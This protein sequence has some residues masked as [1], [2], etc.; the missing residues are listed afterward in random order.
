MTQF[1]L[2][3]IG[4]GP[5]GYE[6]ALEAAAA[7]KHVALI[8]ERAAGG[9]CLHEGC[10]PTKCLAHSAEVLESVKTA[11]A[12]GIGC[13]EATFS[14]PTAVERKD[15]VVQR[16]TAGIDALLKSAGVERIAG[17]AIMTADHTVSVGDDSLTAPHIIIATGSEARRLPIPGADLP[18]VVTSTEMLNLQTVPERLC[19]IGGGVIG[20]EF[21]GI[22]ATLGSTVTVIEYCKEILPPFDKDMAKRLRMILKKKG[23][24]FRLES[25]VERIEANADSGTDIHFQTKG[26][27]ATVQADLVL[28]AVGRA[29]R[30]AGLGLEQTAIAHSP[31]GIVTDDNM[32]TTVAGVYAIGDVN[33]R[34]PL[35]HAATF[36]GRRA[37]HHIL[38]HTDGIDFTLVPSVVYTQ[39]NLAQVGLREEDFADGKPT[40]VKAF[41]RANGRALTM[42]AEEGMVKLLFDADDHLRGAHILGEGA[43]EMIHEAAVLIAEGATRSRLHDIIHAHPTLS[44]MYLA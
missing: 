16:L 23:I 13:G 17:H 6:T 44:E 27:A 9:T 7:G 35:A 21:A 8:E 4:A 43:A 33:N 2:I 40:A 12:F 5:G 42:G 37:L 24:D 41:Y 28:M 26:K 36:Q 3:I 25:A 34:C 39:P 29:P 18:Q 1:D 11:A 19:I 14:L 31:R 38:G 32:Q 20:M 10:I 15:E 30:V 22:F